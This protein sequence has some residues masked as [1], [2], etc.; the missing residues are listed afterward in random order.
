[1]K[2]YRKKLNLRFNHKKYNYNK[3]KKVMSQNSKWAA[4][5]NLLHKPVEVEPIKVAPKVTK[6]VEALE[7]V[8]P[9][10]VEAPPVQEVVE[11]ELDGVIV[12]PKIKKTKTA[13]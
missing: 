6:I 1:L 12:K 9:V 2:N 5:Q 3:E 8:Q 4:W 7:P 11:H 13:E 10:V